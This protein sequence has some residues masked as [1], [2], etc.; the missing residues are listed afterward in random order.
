[1]YARK[2]LSLEIYEDLPEL[3]RRRLLKLATV[4]ELYDDKLK[5]DHSKYVFA[6]LLL[7]KGLN[8][9]DNN[10]CIVLENNIGVFVI[11]RAHCG[12]VYS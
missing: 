8:D 2:N 6:E 10:I 3:F 7:R 1:M 9:F 11:V 12:S 4:Y 5:Y